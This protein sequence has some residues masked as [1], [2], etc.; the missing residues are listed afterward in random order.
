MREIAKRHAKDK[1]RNV[2]NQFI[3]LL[4]YLFVLFVHFYTKQE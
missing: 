4:I 1:T 2:D 3:C